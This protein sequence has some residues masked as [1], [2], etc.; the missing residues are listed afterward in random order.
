[1]K[2]CVFCKIVGGQI[3]TEFEEENNTL[4]V[5]KDIHPKASIHYLIVSKEHK[6]DIME[7]NGEIWVN[8]GK[9]A[10]KLAKKMEIS[11]F[12]LVHN[13]GGAADIAHIHVHFL[14]NVEVDREV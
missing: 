1:M 9:M 5:F 13:A 2:D 12:R 11:N 4:V 8:I 10:K 14:G 7:D 3:P 6:R